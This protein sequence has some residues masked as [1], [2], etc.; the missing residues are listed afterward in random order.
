MLRRLFRLALFLAVLGAVLAAWGYINSIADP[1][2][3]TARLSLPGWPANAPPLRVALLSDVHVQGPDMP[4]DRLRRLAGR[5]N[6]ARPDAVLIAGDLVGDRLVATR[7][8]DDAAI[9]DAIAAFRA[10]HGVFVVLGNHDHWRTPRA[11]VAELR[12]RG[13]TVLSNE[14]A[15]IGPLTLIGIDDEYSHHDD[16]PASIAAADRLGGV[17]L[18]L[19]HSPDV[20]PNL[21]LRWRHIL[22]GHTHCGQVVL[23]LIG[24]PMV[25]SRYGDRYRCGVIRDGARTVIA[26]AGWGNSGLPLRFGAPPDWWLITLG[27]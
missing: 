20:V 8:Y 24:A 22:V 13:V 9:A 18:V 6:A 19:T 17:P 23:P 5:V 11:L 25:P 10:P 16:I 1:V 21:P 3:R 27:R 2:A 4:P 15:P 14:A 12:R 26:G 7:W